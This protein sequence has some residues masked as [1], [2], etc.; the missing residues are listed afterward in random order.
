V[1]NDF[2]DLLQNY[3]STDA[4]M[5]LAEFCTYNR[6][7]HYALFDMM[8]VQTIRTPPSNYHSCDLPCHPEERYPT[9]S[10][11]ANFGECFYYVRQ[12]PNAA[13]AQ[14]EGNGCFRRHGPL[15]PINEMFQPMRQDQVVAA[16][17]Q[18]Q[19]ID[20]I[21]GEPSS[22]VEASL[23]SKFTNPITNS[24]YV[25]NYYNRIQSF[26]QDQ[27]REQ[28]ILSAL[29]TVPL[30]NCRVP[31]MRQ[32]TEANNQALVYLVNVPEPTYAERTGQESNRIVLTTSTIIQNAVSSNAPNQN[33]GL[34]A[35][36][37]RYGYQFNHGVERIDDNLNIITGLQELYDRHPQCYSPYRVQFRY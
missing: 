7:N 13:N 21:N 15:N 35:D 27:L 30:A 2:E 34:V 10:D 31:F 1:I 26:P 18:L 5:S 14:N 29:L 17:K 22:K 25:S 12:H 9:Q 16:F 20:L 28:P 33:A 8:N 32:R 36:R 3:V 11:E 4:S 19:S 23:R 6:K 37:H 24:I